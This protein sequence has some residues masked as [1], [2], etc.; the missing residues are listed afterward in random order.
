MTDFLLDAGANALGFFVAL[1]IYTEIKER[2]DRRRHRRQ[3]ARQQDAMNAAVGESMET[4][5]RMMSDEGCGRPD[6]PN[7]GPKIKARQDAA[8]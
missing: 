5:Q 6:C 1:A 3:Q 4:L 8:N 2:V 7:C